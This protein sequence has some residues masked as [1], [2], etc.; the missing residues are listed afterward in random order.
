MPQAKLLCPL[1]KIKRR[2][3]VEPGP[4]SLFQPCRTISEVKLNPELD[5]ARSAASIQLAKSSAA[6]CVIKLNKLAV[7]EVGAQVR[8][9]A[10]EIRTVEK[11][12]HLRAKLNTI[13]FMNLPILGHREIDISKSRLPHG[14]APKITEMSGSR[15]R[16]RGRIQIYRLVRAMEEERLITNHIGTEA[17]R[18]TAR[19][20]EIQIRSVRHNVER[21]ATIRSDNPIKL[22]ISEDL[23]HKRTM[24]LE[25]GQ[26][27]NRVGNKH[28]PAVKVGI[29]LVQI[30]VEG[31]RGSTRE[32]S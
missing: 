28:M 12:E 11:V 29:T 9:E 3:E 30:I 6:E 20:T 2:A 22:P 17:A 8:I 10:V 13:P 26:D 5:V 1:E 14:S 21:Y 25:R 15:H 32:R 18:G 16:E 24:V 7:V 31:I 23:T 19:Q 4:P 27:I